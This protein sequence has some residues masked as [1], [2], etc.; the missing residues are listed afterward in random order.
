MCVSFAYFVRVCN[1]YVNVWVQH[2]P[3]G[4][5]EAGG[6]EARGWAWVLVG[7]WSL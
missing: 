5:S 4:G 3:H 2:A 1:M 7:Y 6:S